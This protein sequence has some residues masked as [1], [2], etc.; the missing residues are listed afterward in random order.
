M[1]EPAP[2]ACTLAP[3]DLAAQARRWTRLIARSLI[4]RT[5]TA[6]GLRLSFRADAAGELR[7][8]AAAEAACCPWA[9]WRVDQGAGAAVLDIRSAGE[10]VPVLHAMFT[11][12]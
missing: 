2:I 5:E 11:Q 10:G 12:S 8:L 4:A 6:A 9:T 1:T 3:A 7:A